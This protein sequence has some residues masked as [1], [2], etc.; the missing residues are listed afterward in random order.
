MHINNLM[1]AY[2]VQRVA[3][4]LNDQRRSLRGSRILLLGVAYKRDVGDTRE[5]PALTIMSLLSKKGSETSYH[6]PYVPHVQFDGV[7]CDSQPLD[8]EFLES[9]DCVVITTDHSCV[10]YEYVTQHS[11]L[12]FDT[13]NDLKSATGRYPGKVEAL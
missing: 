3:D 5:S 2:V 10:D 12:I 13:R 9:Q 8:I 4:L 7:S 1:P 6:D 11:R